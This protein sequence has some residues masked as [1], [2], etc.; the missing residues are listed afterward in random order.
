M[1][2]MM[3]KHTDGDDGGV[4]EGYDAYGDKDDNDSA[5]ADDGVCI[6]GCMREC[7]C[8][9]PFRFLCRCIGQVALLTVCVVFLALSCLR[10]CGIPRLADS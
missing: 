10:G 5:D 9:C 2:S 1:V 3:M 7:P 6:R 4:D 8:R